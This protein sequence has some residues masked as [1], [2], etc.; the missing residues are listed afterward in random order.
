MIAS[1]ACA[2][3][4]FDVAFSRRICCSRVCNAR[5]KAGLPCRSIDWPTSR[6]GMRSFVSVLGRH[7]TRVRSA[8][9]KRNAKSLR[10]ADRDI[11]T[12]FARSSATASAPTN[13]WP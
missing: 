3:Q 10:I 11:G 13:R 4:I 1:K 9:A 12:Q 7:E 5:R 2:V 8:K 6:P